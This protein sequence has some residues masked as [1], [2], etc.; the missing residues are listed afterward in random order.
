MG[1]KDS[2]IWIVAAQAKDGDYG[3]RSLWL[4]FRRASK[5]DAA[6]DV[7]YEVRNG[8]AATVESESLHAAAIK[9]A[10]G[11]TFYYNTSSDAD[12]TVCLQANRDEHNRSHWY[13]ARVERCSI[14]GDVARAI[15]RLSGL[16]VWDTQPEEI[17][18]T[19]RA[20]PAQ[21]CREAGV[22]I[23]ADIDDALLSPLQRVEREVEQQNQPRAA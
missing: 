23:E 14:N 19:L 21:Y 5:K 10:T 8:T 15:L 20:L 12:F 1:H 2:S 22:Y 18:S 13:G 17:I 4:H 6:D 11:D 3:I 7:A 9:H 16:N